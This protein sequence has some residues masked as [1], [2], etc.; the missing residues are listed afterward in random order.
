MTHP[1]YSQHAL[2]ALPTVQLK[3][4]A[5]QI[6]AIPDGDKRSKQVWVNAIIQH[7]TAFSP[8]KVAAMQAHIETVM[9][10]MES[11]VPD[12]DES[13]LMQTSKPTAETIEPSTSPEKVLNS[14]STIDSPSP[15]P[16]PNTQSL[17]QTAPLPNRVKADLVDVLEPAPQ[18]SE[19]A[20]H[21]QQKGASTVGLILVLAFGLAILI[22]KLGFTS[23]S[24][25]LTALLPLAVVLWGYLFPSQKHQ[26]SIDY[27]PQ[28]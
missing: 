1:A 2:E 21:S 15:T 18:V 19:Q 9:N 11:V 8:V 14:K 22:I 7:Q 6:G 4:I 5:K 27:F 23:I 26:D 24:W 3:A 25:I 20:T 16:E 28:V 13:A 10:R 17:K 12:A